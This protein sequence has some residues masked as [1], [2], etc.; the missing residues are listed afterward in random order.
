[1]ISIKEKY[2]IDNNGNPVSVILS[3]KDYDRIVDYIEELEDIAIYDKT[4]M[5]KGAS[6][7]WEKR[8]R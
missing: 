1:M 6:V 5:Q 8:K 4:K 7:P 3:K 2:V